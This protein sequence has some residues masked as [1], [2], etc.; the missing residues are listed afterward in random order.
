MEYERFPRRIV[1]GNAFCNREKERTMLA[2]LLRQGS[3]VWLQAHRRHGKTSLLLQTVEDMKSNNENIVVERCH[4]LFTSGMESIIKQILQSV[5]KLTAEIIEFEH[6]QGEHGK[7]QAFL[8]KVMG[9]FSRLN[10]TVSMDKGKLSLSFETHN[11][12]D[13]LR[14]ASKNW[15]SWQ[16]STVSGLY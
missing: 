14:K 12:V 7:S 9:S 1:T 5:S 8:D 11:D 4:L 6:C 2:K 15:M 10:P 16:L 3:H 13:A